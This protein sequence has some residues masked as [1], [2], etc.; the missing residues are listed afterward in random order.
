MRIQAESGFPT[1]G[2]F[3]GQLPENATV[4]A[5][6]YNVFSDPANTT[7]RSVSGFGNR[8]FQFDVFGPRA[9]DAQLLA[10]AI[11]RVLNGFS[12]ALPD[13]DST[14]V[15]SIIRTDRMGPKYSD[16]ARNFWV[17]LE[18]SVWYYGQ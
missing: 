4:P 2:G 17:M 10:N 3:A 5:Y 9:V 18:Y 12:G 6:T 13:P 11:D 15:D 14:K 16:S 8:R 7:L 1:A